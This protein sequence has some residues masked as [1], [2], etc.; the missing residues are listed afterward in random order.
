MS[1]LLCQIARAVLHVLRSALHAVK[2][3]SWRFILIFLDICEKCKKNSYLSTVQTKIFTTL[4]T[5]LYIFSFVLCKTGQNFYI[6]SYCLIVIV[7]WLLA[8][9][10]YF[11][12]SRVSLRLLLIFPEITSQYYI[13]GKYGY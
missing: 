3:V 7:S 8:L 4:V 9:C 13:S 2:V 1:F 6:Y 10:A 5:H 11:R 12:L